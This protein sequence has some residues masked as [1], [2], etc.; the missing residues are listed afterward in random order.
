MESKCI[1]LSGSTNLVDTQTPH[2]AAE[3]YKTYLMCAAKIIK[4]QGGTN[5]RL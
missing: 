5:Y 2:F 3:I 1:D 4:E